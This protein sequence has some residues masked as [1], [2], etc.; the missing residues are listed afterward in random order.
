MTRQLEHA[1][2][3]GASNRRPDTPAVLGFVY[4]D[5]GPRQGETHDE[6]LFCA[7]DVPT[8]GFQIVR[9]YHLRS[10]ERWVRQ[11]QLEPLGGKAVT[12]VGVGTLGSQVADLLAKAGVGRFTL[13]DA[14]IVTHGNRVRNQLDLT[15]VGRAKVHAVAERLLSVN[16]W[17]TVGRLPLRVG[18]VGSVGEEAL[19][20]KTT[21]DVSELMRHSDLIVNTTADSAA[22]SHL[23]AV[24][25]ESQTAVVH[26]WV[27]AGA[28]GARVLLQRPGQSACWECLALAQEHPERYDEEVSIPAI[29][30]DPAVQQVAEHGCADLSFTG[31]GFE[32]AS[33]SAAVARVVVQAL[34]RQDGGYPPPDSTSLPSTFAMRKAPPRRVDTPAF[35]PIRTARSAKDDTRPVRPSPCGR[36]HDDIAGAAI[37]SGRVA[38][39]LLVG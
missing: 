22:G 29:S 20:Q 5:E 8:T 30:D 32:L 15:D 26:G 25:V 24:G 14:D 18:S 34:L 2:Q 7:I 3:L 39:R 12:I 28:W 37:R 36:S 38:A 27:S 33:A 13:I 11:P 1:R 4:P 6:W 35:R 19:V 21:D 9:S 10:D 17:C 23:S 16:P 31:P